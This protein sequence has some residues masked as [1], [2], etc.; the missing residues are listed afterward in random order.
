MD[1][2]RDGDPADALY[3]KGLIFYNQRRY[4]KA[5]DHFSRALERDST[6]GEV[7]ALRALSRILLPEPNLPL[8]DI[9]QGLAL[10]AASIDE[11][12]RNLRFLLLTF[13]AAALYQSG[14][15]E[16][17]VT[18]LDTAAALGSLDAH[19][20]MRQGASYHELAQ[21][22]LSREAYRRGLNDPGRL[23]VSTELLLLA[24]QDLMELGDSAAALEATAI[25][26]RGQPE[27]ALAWTKQ[28]R[29]LLA[30]QRYEES[31]DSIEHALSLNAQ[32]AQY[33]QEYFSWGVKAAALR[34]LN[35]Y[36]EAHEA[37]HRAYVLAPNP[38]AREPAFHGNFRMLLRL[39]RLKTAW[40]LLIGEVEKRL[41]ERRIPH[42]TGG[43]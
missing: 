25:I 11:G 40:R 41:R 22:D 33:A 9:N 37:Y 27:N 24:A 38:V 17:V 29:A 35:R 39:R 42:A 43:P 19:D 16:Q 2:P 32:D 23:N 15:Y 7:W 3:R 30:L 5:R 26:L 4:V 18:D 1:T 20:F 21:F 10:L 31:L 34:G 13:R 14:Q 28:A 8:E 36:E 12:S 6:R